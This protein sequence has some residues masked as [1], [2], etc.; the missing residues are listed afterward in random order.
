MFKARK[1][2]IRRRPMTKTEDES[3]DEGNISDASVGTAPAPAP[4]PVAAPPPGAGAGA[5][6]GG[7]D[8]RP[9]K[10]RKKAKAKVDKGPKPVLSFGHEDDEESG[11]V[12]KVGKEAKGADGVFRVKRSKASKAMAKAAKD[13][14]ELPAA[15]QNDTARGSWHT[16][17]AGM[18]TAEGLAELR[19]T[20]AFTPKTSSSA[21]N[22]R[23]RGGGAKSER[24]FAG[25][26][27]E[28]VHE[29]GQ[30]GDLKGE[31]LDDDQ[32]SRL[33][34]QREALLAAREAREKDDGGDDF[35]P[36]DGKVGTGRGERANPSPPL[37]PPAFRR[38]H[39]TNRCF[40]WEEE[41]VRRGARQSASK[42]KPPQQQQQQQQSGWGAG[43]FG[44]SAVALNGSGGGGNGWGGS[45]AERPRFLG[46]D[47][48]QKALREAGKQLRETH[49][50]NERQLQVLVSESATQASEEEK[51]VSQQ[52]EA[53]ERFVFFQA[54]RT[55]LSDL[56]GMLREKESM[57]SEVESAKRL[58]HARRLQRAL[59]VRADDQEDHLL[60]ARDAGA[61]IA[62]LGPYRATPGGP[63][64]RAPP[65]TTSAGVGS[66]GG[67][68][69]DRVRRRGERER[70]RRRF[71]R[72]GGG[73]GEGWVDSKSFMW[74]KKE[75]LEV[76]QALRSEGEES[77][78]EG[79]REEERS[80]RLMEAA[81]MVMEDVDDNVK[82]VAEVKALFESWKR[83]HGDQYAQAY[84]T[85][86]L[87]KLFAPFVRLEV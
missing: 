53:A 1:K 9:K 15:P 67:G 61:T 59:E 23:V 44:G 84:C 11:A 33:K 13:K 62:T 71:V 42:P 82:S 16:A 6:P 45:G 26:E 49:E 43:A 54:T 18:Y 64:S 75:R 70:R 39:L 19:S 41:Q 37:P 77:E 47:E 87:P 25:D 21:R 86:T 56:C 4:A 40:R 55:A 36:L 24:V 30:Q 27:A 3:D 7:A 63:L 85:L 51:V 38:D 72:G 66:P 17:T 31:G 76:W 68:G 73:D 81:E 46:V 22:R 20:Q 69:E 28:M 58:L 34:G 78:G 2:D 48:M 50:R 83:H 8:G 57:L 14:T 52:K 5:G 65:L 29:A 60:D 35:I 10:M 74:G 12:D 32:M 79:E 80:R